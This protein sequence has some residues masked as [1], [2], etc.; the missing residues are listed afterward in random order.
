MLPVE[1]KSVYDILV[2]ILGES[3][4]GGFS[5]SVS[6]YQFNSIWITEEN[7]GIPDNK[8]NLEVSLSLGKY[9]DWSTEHGGNLS[10][11]IKQWGNKDLL[12]EYFTILKDLKESQYYNIE[13]F[14]DT[15]VSN[16]YNNGLI[17]PITYTKINI[18]K[19]RKK[20]L[21]DFL[22]SRKITQ[23]LIDF[24]NIGYTTW[25]EDEWQMRDRIIVPS[26][27]CNGILNYWVG[28]DFSGYKSK[29]KYKNCKADKKQIIYQE[30]KIQWDADIILVEGVLDA[31]RYPNS[32]SLTGK[33]LTK[34]SELYKTLFEK[35]NANIIICLDGDTTINEIKKIYNILNKGR[36]KDKIWYIRLGTEALPW[37]DFSEAYEN[38]G[39]KGI[40]KIMKEKQQFSEIE[41]LT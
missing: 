15:E 17:L 5:T 34:D 4:Q 31:I 24:Y 12:N 25:D 2:L 40:I 23:D 30:D 1:L 32:I 26:Y 38:D 36:L 18:D 7:S 6:Q 37:K 16:D 39:K 20:K 21:L 14:K 33:A 19:C 27:D 8:Y 9:H 13:L 3:K 35:A 10:R 28:R 22:E 41:L 11:L 29:V